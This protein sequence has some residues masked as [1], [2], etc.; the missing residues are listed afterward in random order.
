MYP[1]QMQPTPPPTPQ[2]GAPIDYLNQISAKPQKKILLGGMKQR[3]ILGA[4]GLIVALILI[5]IIGALLRPNLTPDEQLAAKLQ[6]TNSIALSAQSAIQSS[7]LR[8][9]NSNLTINLTNAIRDIHQ[10]LL[11]NGID[12]TKLDSSIVKSE[13]GTDITARLEDARLNGVY[14]ATYAREIAYQ[15]ELITS[16]M[17][18]IYKTTSSKSLKAFLSTAYTNFTPIQKQFEDFNDA[19]S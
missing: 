12:S 18:Q 10:P 14:D 17:Q 4:A 13:A 1:N 11:N 6:A 16:S 19:N 9:F 5:A 8:A 7:Q 2:T 15:L 3:I